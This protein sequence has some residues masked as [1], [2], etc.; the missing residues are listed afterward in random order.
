MEKRRLS[1][2]KLRH[3][4]RVARNVCFPV[5]EPH[6]L[7]IAPFAGALTGAEVSTCAGAHGQEMVFFIVGKRHVQQIGFPRASSRSPRS[8]RKGIARTW[9]IENVVFLVGKEWFGAW[10]RQRPSLLKVS[11]PLLKK[12]HVCRVVRAAPRLCFRKCQFSS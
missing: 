3:G 1:K 10:A 12:Y 6:I 5:W 11:A 9:P 2:T 7:H 8:V 4:G